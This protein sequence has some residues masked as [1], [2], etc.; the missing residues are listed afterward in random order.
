MAAYSPTRVSGSFR[1]LVWV[2]RAGAE[3]PAIRVRGMSRPFNLSPDG[4]RVVR[5]NTV[6]P[7]RNLW[8]DDVRRGTATQLTVRGTNVQ[9]GVWSTDGSWIVFAQG[10]PVLN[11]FRIAPDGRGA[12]ERLTT[13][14]VDQFPSSWS[15]DGRLLA[16]AEFDPQ[17]GSDIWLLDVPVTLSARSSGREPG[18]DTKR[19]FLR[20]PFSDGSAVFSPDGRWLAYQSNESGRFEVYVQPVSG[21]GRK[22]QVSTDGGIV[23]KWSPTGRELFYRSSDQLMAA[24]VQVGDAFAT[25]P[26][27]PLFR[28]G[29]ES[30][31]GVSPDGSRFLLMRLIA[32]EASAT[33]V[34]LI[35]DWLAELRQ[36]VR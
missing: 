33:S 18:A 15:P 32:N 31:F 25:A 24:D 26:A 10:L 27:R 14:T 5:N 12:E 30:D 36:R 4:T 16:L 21:S 3:E 17:T 23:P 6:G 20:T 35:S 28:G 11:L 29:Y 1:D 34:V 19:A 13:S 2:N 8:T 7:S 22:Y 9:S